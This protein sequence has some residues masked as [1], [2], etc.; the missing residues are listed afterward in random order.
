MQD[1]DGVPWGGGRGK[2]GVVV[3][4]RGEEGGHV[5][6]EGRVGAR[7]AVVGGVVD[8]EADLDVDYEEDGGRGGGGEGSGVGG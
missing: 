5:G 6:F 8:V 1:G 4:A 3:P 2:V 7:K